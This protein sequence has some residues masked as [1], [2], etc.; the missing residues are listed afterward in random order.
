[1]DKNSWFNLDEDDI[2]TRVDEMLVSWK[3]L[4]RDPGHSRYFGY[5]SME[6]LTESKRRMFRQKVITLLNEDQ[7]LKRSV[8][9]KRKDQEH[10]DQMDQLLKR[11]T[12]YE[13]KE[14]EHFDQMEVRFDQLE[15]LIL[16]LIVNVNKQSASCTKMDGH[17]NF[18]EG[19]YETLRSPLDYVTSRV[20]RLRGVEG[21][22]LPLPRIENRE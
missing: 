12:E 3:G 19:A 16:D 15:K 14:Q 21:D 13:R 11:L 22:E 6:K 8:E 7:L 2:N 4:L 20:N 18:V 9:N 5:G 17:I 10:F 1:M